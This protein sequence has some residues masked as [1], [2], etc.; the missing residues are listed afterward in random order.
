MS[1]DSSNSSSYDF[2][3]NPTRDALIDGLMSFIKPGIDNLDEGIEMAKSSQIK[4][5]HQLDTLSKDIDEIN[6]SQKVVPYDL[7]VYTDTV[8]HIRYRFTIITNVLRA[9]HDRLQSLVGQVNIIK[10]NNK[11]H[12][13]ENDSSRLM[14]SKKKELNAE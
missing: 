2:T 6:A 13:G 9:A 7:Q 10:A 11:S 8:A 3:D 14:V 12:F 5:Q 1:S 4:L